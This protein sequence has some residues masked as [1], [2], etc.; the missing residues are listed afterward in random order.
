M[1]IFLDLDG[2]LVREDQ[3]GVKIDHSIILEDEDIF[4]FERECQ[5][6]FEAVIN[7]HDHARIVISSSWIEICTIDTIKSLFVA[8]VAAKI[9]GA[10]PRAR[11]AC[12]DPEKYYRHL[13]VLDYIKQHALE[14]VPWVAIDDIREHYAPIAPII[15]TNPYTG[16]RQIDAERLDY[17]LR[18][19][20][21][22]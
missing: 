14:S 2:V 5:D 3:P 8:S 1:Y 21:L 10:T 11:E 19:G 6:I 20:T 9:M 17:F 7:K 15:V 18:Y 12:N 22:E 13:E 4:K 16:F